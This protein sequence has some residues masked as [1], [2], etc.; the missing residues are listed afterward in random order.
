MLYVHSLA[1]L[2][3]GK[4]ALRSHGFILKNMK[5]QFYV[6]Y[7]SKRKV[8]IQ[9]QM[10]YAPPLAGVCLN[11]FDRVDLCYKH[12]VNGHI[13]LYVLMANDL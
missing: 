5:Y 11:K 9:T 2:M 6:M 12:I 8:K 13:G 10:D 7:I 4:I 1:N 3:A